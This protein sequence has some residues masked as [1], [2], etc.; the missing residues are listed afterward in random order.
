MATN[1]LIP[2]RTILKQ[3]IGG[4]SG[5]M[6]AAALPNL[7]AADETSPEKVA[8][9]PKVCGPFPILSTPYAEDGE[10][11]Y[12]VLAQEAKF[13]AW[14]GTPGMIW[15]QSGDSID[16]LTAD[17][18][19]NGM[20]VLAETTRGSATALC[21]GVQGNDT[22]EMLQFAAHAE[23]LNPTAII[24]RPPDSGKT[25]ED[26]RQY[27]RA[28]AQV[29]TRPVILQT[30]GG[31]A[32]K[33]PLP[34]PKLMIELAAEFPHFGYIKEEAGDV[35]ER[36]K[37]SLAARPPVRRVFSARGGFHWLEE[38]RLGSEG[39]ITE[40]AAY[41][42]LLT[43][44]W[45]LQQSGDDPEKLEEMFGKFIQMVK[46]KPGGLRDANLY[47]WKKRGVFKNLLS[48]VYGPNKSIPTTPILTE[49]KMNNEKVAE[50]E[51]RFAA[52]KPYLKE[53]SPD[54]SQPS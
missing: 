34:S 17:E 4:A 8:P 1:H 20:E 2:R 24:S 30:T 41:A 28:L 42:D 11:D 16:L 3:A 27:W 39:V 19:R 33:G 38:S 5:L 51:A 6:A 9:D 36:M 12:D 47:I 23:K 46:V 40:R 50:V 43:E 54:L 10:V 32:Y 18:K 52:L 14:A 25:E 48:R 15:P 44:I 22:A 49:F 31:V 7:L 53:V 13:V 45:S 21:L 35:L 26:L 37:T 29:A